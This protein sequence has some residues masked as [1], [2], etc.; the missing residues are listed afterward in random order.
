MTRSRINL[1]IWLTMIV[2]GSPLF[3]YVIR[4]RWVH[5]ISTA[6]GLTFGLVA[7]VAIGGARRGDTRELGAIAAFLV[8]AGFFGRGGLAHFGWVRPITDWEWALLYSMACVSV[9]YLTLA[10]AD[11]FGARRLWQRVRRR[12]RID[13]TTRR[14]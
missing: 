9:I 12:S 7:M 8:N 6:F 1:V 10:Y 13:G 3:Y 4:D 14:G 11:Y 2:G 5:G